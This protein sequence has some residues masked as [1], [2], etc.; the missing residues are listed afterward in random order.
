MHCGHAHPNRHTLTDSSKHRLN[1]VQIYRLIWKWS[2]YYKHT[3]YNKFPRIHGAACF[4]TV[5]IFYLAALVYQRNKQQRTLQWVLIKIN[6]NINILEKK[7]LRGNY[8][9]F[10]I[11]QEKTSKIQLHP[12]IWVISLQGDFLCSL[13]ELAFLM[14]ELTLWRRGWVG[15]APALPWK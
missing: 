5:F 7:Y 1:W 15:G 2:P 9:I 4:S 14:N 13:L 3:E 8:H 10:L 6:N 11:K 12:V